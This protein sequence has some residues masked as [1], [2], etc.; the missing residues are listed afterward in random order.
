M[1]EVEA[2]WQ[3][4]LAKVPTLRHKEILWGERWPSSMSDAMAT[5]AELTH[6][7]SIAQPP[8]KKVHTG[9]ASKHNTSW[10][11][12]AIQTDRQ[13]QLRMGFDFT[14]G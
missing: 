4:M 8:M 9:K 11:L 3:K 12:E 7:K 6:M 2:R 14:P 10:L 5:I 1:D 13:Y